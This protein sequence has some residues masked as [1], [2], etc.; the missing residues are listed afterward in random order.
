[1][2]DHMLFTCTGRFQARDFDFLAEVMAK[3]GDGAAFLR[4]IEDR[5]ELH[6]ILDDRRVLG[7]LLESP[8]LLD[9]SPWCYFYVLVRHSLLGGGLDDLALAEYLGAV[10]AERMN[11]HGGRGGIPAE[12]LYSVDFLQ[13]LEQTTGDRRFEL[14]VAGGNQFLLL[15]GVF[16]EFV[17]HRSQRRGAPGVRFYENV[18]RAS[19][20]EAQEHPLAV[21]GGIKGVLGTLSEVLPETRRSLNRMAD[22]LL[23]LAN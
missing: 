9:V 6:A 23:F 3:S 18:A 1:M 4:Y 21:R 16:R 20:R 11:V 12:M 10:L 14:L 7:A 15:T 17:E 8:S 19:F 22:S 5:D 2:E 13:V